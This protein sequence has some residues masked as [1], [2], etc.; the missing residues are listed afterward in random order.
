MTVIFETS[1]YFPPLQY[2]RKR[3][4]PVLCLPRVLQHLEQRHWLDQRTKG[5]FVEFVVFNANVN[6]FCVVI[7]MLESSDVGTKASLFSPL[8][9]ILCFG[10]DVC[11][12]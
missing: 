8:S 10:L 6:L 4:D 12:L 2:W 3:A 1:G 9:M 11:P 7:L 5:L